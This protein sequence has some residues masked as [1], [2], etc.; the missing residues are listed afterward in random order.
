[1]KG[2]MSKAEWM[3]ALAMFLVELLNLLA[4]LATFLHVS[5]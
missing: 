2:S 4:N 5:R 1:M 3:L